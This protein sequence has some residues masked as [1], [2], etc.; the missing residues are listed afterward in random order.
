MLFLTY[1]RALRS[2]FDQFFLYLKCYLKQTKNENTFKSLGALTNKAIKFTC[3]LKRALGDQLYR[4][5]VK[6]ERFWLEE[7]KLRLQTFLHWIGGWF[8]ETAVSNEASFY[9][10][11][12]IKK[13]ILLCYSFPE[14]VVIVTMVISFKNN[15]EK[16]YRGFYI[17]KQPPFFPA[18]TG[19]SS[20]AGEI[21][22]LI[23]KIEWQ[24]GKQMML[25]KFELGKAFVRACLIGV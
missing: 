1:H 12:S 11:V 22:F 10:W 19:M 18:G 21:N 15:R 7:I 24:Q 8:Y 20:S 13:M 9:T 5:Q 3:S 2:R 17:T 6:Q 25:T 23:M 16:Y 4:G 14:W